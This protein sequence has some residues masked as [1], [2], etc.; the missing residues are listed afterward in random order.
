VFTVDVH[1]IKAVDRLRALSRGELADKHPLASRLAAEL[2]RPHVLLMSTLLH[3]IGKDIGGTGHSERGAELAVRVAERLHLGA[4][5]V[6]EIRHLVRKHLRMYQMATRRDIDDEAT[7][8]EFSRDVHGHEGLRELYLLTVADVST[9]SPTALTSWKAR[10]LEELYVATERW[11]SEGARPQDEGSEAAL[12]GVFELVHDEG[13]ADFLLEF[14]KAMPERYLYGNSPADIARHGQLART[15]LTKRALVACVSADG[16]YLEL[17]FVAQDRPGLLA[18]I[19]ATLASAGLQVVGAQ[20]YSWVGRDGVTR[21]FDLFWV[22]AGSRARVVDRL[23]AGLER[24]L[25]GLED[26]ELSAEQ[27]V[28]TKRQGAGQ[29]ARHMPEVRTQISIDNRAAARS[30]VLEVT[31]QDR[32]GLL[33]R[34]ANALQQLGLRISLA[35]INTEGTLVADVFYVNDEN[36][37]K[38][39]DPARVEQLK[40]RILHALGDSEV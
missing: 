32:P 6:A 2:A 11:L 28:A 10:M 1:S 24:D 13:E 37:S 27:L 33:F 18:M 40:Q 22:G 29:Y 15:S 31:T 5:D 4:A 34:L 19:T 39:T 8:Q 36:D 25:L 16:P 35:K 7:L 38:L 9:T 23:V 30:T 26:G 12:R 14:L 17:V 21:A 20:V 3:D